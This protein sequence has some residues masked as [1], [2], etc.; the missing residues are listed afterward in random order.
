MT[1]YYKCVFDRNG[2]IMNFY[3]CRMEKVRHFIKLWIKQ[4]QMLFLGGVLL[5][6]PFS[7][8][9]MTNP[10]TLWNGLL[11]KDGYGWETGLGRW[12]LKIL[13]QLK[14]YT[15]SPAA[16]TIFSILILS[17][18]CMLVCRL[19]DI[20]SSF[21]V[22][23]T[24]IFL[25]ASPNIA[26]TL[27]YY[28]CSDFY[29]IAYFLNVLAIYI[30][31]RHKGIVSWFI[32][33]LA[34]A[35]S[36]TLYQAYISIAIVLSV[37]LLI[38]MLFEVEIEERQILRKVIKL[39]IVGGGGA[40]IYLLLTRWQARRGMFSLIADRGF[41]EMGNI[42]F[43][44]LPGQIMNCYVEFI[45]YFFRN[46]FL[47]NNWLHRKYW[48]L[49]LFLTLII[50]GII[51]LWQNR[52]KF[53]WV[54]LFLLILAG[55]LLP[56]GCYIMLIIAPKV[57]LYESTGILLIP[58]MNYVYILWLM[59][60]WRIKGQ[61]FA[62][63]IKKCII[64][65]GSVMVGGIL[66][67][68]VS[69]FQSCMQ[70]NLMKTYSAATA[71]LREIDEVSGGITDY[72]I[73]ISGDVNLGNEELYS[74]VKG[75]V[76]HYGMAWSDINGRNNCWKAIFEIYFGREYSVCDREEC[77]QIMA[78]EIYREMPAYPEKGYVKRIEDNV[79]V[80]LDES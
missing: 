26:D 7:T 25:I 3:D 13:A 1:G 28:Y 52:K 24:G 37:L 66:L 9:F 5:Y 47:N 17:I 53:S 41:S 8:H 51:L 50:F 79:V 57:S 71:I 58:A 16:V 14:G 64:P 31:Y 75:T 21:L 35:F 42:D 38:K 70:N 12:G 40:A 65:L 15:I 48:N 4:Y 46:V 77:E 36:L 63:I 67:L 34:V 80:K 56:V 73:M 78:G 76:A 54:R 44:K 2:R 55:M 20:E 39:M 30:A 59:L 69:V 72:P 60:A 29:I 43:S 22:I 18:I 6:L 61:Y 10:D 32:P 68:F 49:F 62:F 45:N 23:L 74:I 11:Y 33:V 27:T 19:F